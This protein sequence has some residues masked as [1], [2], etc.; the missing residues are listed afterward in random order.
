MCS[1]DVKVMDKQRTC[2]T[3]Y[4]VTPI[5]QVIRRASGGGAGS[6][7]DGA[8]DSYSTLRSEG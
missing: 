1:S 8:A 4:T 3:L 5:I 6:S 2:G 7:A